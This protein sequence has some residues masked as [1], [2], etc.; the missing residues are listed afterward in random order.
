MRATQTIPTKVAGWAVALSLVALSFAAASATGVAP[1]VEWTDLFEDP[2]GDVTGYGVHPVP[3]AVSDSVDL[4]AGS[5]ALDDDGDTLA[6]AL[7]LAEAPDTVGRTVVTAT[8]AGWAFA[9]ADDDGTPYSV[10]ARPFAFGPGSTQLVARLCSEGQEVNTNLGLSA[11]LDEEA[12]LV[13]W[14]LPVREANYDFRGTLTD[15]HGWSP[16]TSP[17][18]PSVIDCDVPP[19]QGALDRAPDAGFGSDFDAGGG[20]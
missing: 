14:T 13:V 1:S 6:I 20:P 7:E 17:L 10:R 18:G 15:T 8:R 16:R 11:S 4:V 19:W 3:R 5:M 12:D 2:V 9:F